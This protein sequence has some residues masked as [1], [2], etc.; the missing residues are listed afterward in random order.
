MHFSQI[1]LHR[2]QIKLAGDHVDHVADERSAAGSKNQLRYS[3]RRS[4][5]RFEIGAAFESVRGVGVNAVPLRHTAH[6]DRVPPRGFDQDVLRFLRDHG[7]EAAHH[8]SQS[9]R[10]F[11]VGNDEIFDGKLALHAIQSFQRFAGLGAANDQ[12]AAFEQI[13][14]EHMRGL[15]TLPQDVV[16]RVHRIA[17]RSLIQQPQASGNMRRRR[18][19]SDAA[20]FARREART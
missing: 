4:D 15:A 19:N 7:V 16:C 20:N 14:V 1:E 8:S 5:G 9:H 10:L 12:P 3:V 6:R 11:R 17:D 13:E 18:F 2:S